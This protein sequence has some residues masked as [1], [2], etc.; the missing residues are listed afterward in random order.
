[1]SPQKTFLDI[2]HVEILSLQPEMNRSGPVEECE[3]CE[4]AVEKEN[5]EQYLIEPL[6]SRCWVI[7]YTPPDWVS[8]A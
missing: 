3:E 5:Q 7:L 2:F 4:F 8:A 1:M 6:S